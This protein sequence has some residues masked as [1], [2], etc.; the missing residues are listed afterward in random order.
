MGKDRIV[1]EL[2]IEKVNIPHRP[3]RMVCLI[4]LYFRKVLFLQ[5]NCEDKYREFPYV[6]HPVSPLLISYYRGTFVLIETN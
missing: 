5:K 3:Y 6:L 4:T 1:K 2:H